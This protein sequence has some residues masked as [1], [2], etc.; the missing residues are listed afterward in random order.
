MRRTEI[1]PERVAVMSNEAKSMKFLFTLLSGPQHPGPQSP[2]VP[3]SV[4]HGT[5]AERVK[6]LVTQFP[7]LSAGLSWFPGGPPAPPGVQSGSCRPAFPGWC[8]DHE[9]ITARLKT[10]LPDGAN[11]TLIVLTFIV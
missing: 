9:S 11:G 1:I 6:L 3:L 7:R 5:E 2:R 10:P 4:G 8:L